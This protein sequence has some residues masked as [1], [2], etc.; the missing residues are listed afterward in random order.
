MSI[1]IEVNRMNAGRM[2]EL[3]RMINDY[4]LPGSM[5][6]EMLLTDYNECLKDGTAF[7]NGSMAASFTDEFDHE[8]TFALD[9]REIGYVTAGLHNKIER[10]FDDLAPRAAMSVESD[11]EE[12]L[13]DD[14]D[15]DWDDDRDDDEEDEDVFWLEPV[16]SEKT[17]NDLLDHLLDDDGGGADD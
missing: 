10:V 14:W 2:A 17:F 5:L 6:V 4:S 8:L 11:D 7:S 3:D 16:N 9:W 12:D 15:D 13:D 1:K